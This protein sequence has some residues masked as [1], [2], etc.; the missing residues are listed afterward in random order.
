MDTGSLT[1]IDPSWA[2][3]IAA[4]GALFTAIG[5]VVMAISVL[6]PT[7]RASKVAVDKV[8]EVHQLVNSSHTALLQYQA[9]LVGALRDADMVVPTDHSYRPAEAH[10]SG[11][12]PPRLGLPDAPQPEQGSIR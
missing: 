5:G 8:E 2:A 1:T 6:V 7:M 9:R 3:I 4:I 12:V 11:P 10:P